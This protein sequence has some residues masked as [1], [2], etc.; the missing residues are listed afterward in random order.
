MVK[1]KTKPIQEA[2]REDE[3]ALVSVVENEKTEVLLRGHR[4]KVGWM[5]PATADWI[6]ALMTKDGD[7]NK[8]LAKCAALIRL[9]GFWKCHLFYWCVWRWYYYIRQYTSAELTPLFEVAQKKTAQEAAPAYLNATI[10]LTALSTTKKQ[11]TKAEAE[12]TL[13]ALRTDNDGKSQKSTASTQARSR[14]SASPS[15]E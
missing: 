4:L 12:R 1:K 2:T 7:E 3:Q 9:N 15:A 14:S 5:H 11:M 10:L 13:R 8:V 6:S